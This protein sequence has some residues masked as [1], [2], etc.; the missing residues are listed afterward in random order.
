MAEQ[1]RGLFEK[2]VDWQQAQLL[3][4]GRL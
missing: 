2:L 4:R 1:L 3:C